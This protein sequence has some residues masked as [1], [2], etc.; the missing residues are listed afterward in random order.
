MT[1]ELLL[2]DKP[3]GIT[4]FDVIRILRKKLKVRKMGHAGTLDPN[5]T[6]LLLIGVGNGTKKLHELLGMSK[7]YIA[8]I[9]LGIKTSTGDIC[10]EVIESKP[11]TNISL[12]KIKEILKSLEGEIE[13]R[14]PIYSAIKIK[15]KP[16]YKYARQ[17]EEI[18]PPK[19]IMT[20]LN[21]Q[22]LNFDPENNLVEISFKV[23]S[24]TYIRSIT[25]EFGERLET[26]ATL[27]N[28]RRI[29]IGNFS[30]NSAKSLD[31]IN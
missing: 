26:V 10:G 31:S 25:E 20:V 11:V 6:G 9:L 17:K 16:L 19:K 5:A 28:L 23:K 27:N 2:I 22:L 4:S 12:E 8:E 7:E 24:G 13:I 18:E 1:E 14:V 29:S 15:G 21:A 3:K 30:V